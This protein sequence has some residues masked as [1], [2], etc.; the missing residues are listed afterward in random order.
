MSKSYFI[1]ADIEGRSAKFEGREP[2]TR[3]KVE[4][5]N[6]TPVVAFETKDGAVLVPMTHSIRY[7]QVVRED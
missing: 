7:V 4:N 1:V 3:P 6:E 2:D 5:S